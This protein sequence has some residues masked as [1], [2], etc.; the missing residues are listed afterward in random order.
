MAG[1]TATSFT[2]MGTSIASVVNIRKMAEKMGNCNQALYDLK[3]VKGQLI[4]EIDS[5]DENKPEVKAAHTTVGKTEKILSSCKQFD[6]EMLGKLHNQSAATATVS[7]VGG[8]VGLAGTITSA[9][10]NSNKVRND[11]TDKG[12]KKE[13]ALNLMSNISAGVVTGTSAASTIISSISAD[14]AK[15]ESKKAGECEDT[16]SS[17]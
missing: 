1:A 13:K 10:A 2:S 6:G 8:A 11:N 9:I 5:E 12:K 15:K 16:L 17:I 3:V 14:V 4:A 7:G